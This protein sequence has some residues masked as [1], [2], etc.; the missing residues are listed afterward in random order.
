M[1]GR[2]SL[3]APDRFSLGGNIMPHVVE[4]V[5]FYLKKKVALTD[6]KDM[7]DKFNKGF[8]ANQQ[9][10]GH[11]IF[12]GGSTMNEQRFEMSDVIR[13]KKGISG[14]WEGA[15]II[16]DTETGVQY[17]LAFYGEAGGLTPLIDKDGKPL[18]D[19]NYSHRSYHPN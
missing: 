14:L 10:S 6:F 17:L 13:T 7:S 8:Q 4:F 12:F 16:T 3:A 9:G 1:V 11:F 2:S 19:R 18:Q 5:T 15:R